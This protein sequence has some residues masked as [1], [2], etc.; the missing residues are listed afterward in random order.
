MRNQEINNSEIKRFTWSGN[1]PMDNEKIVKIVKD[2][3]SG[4]E[5]KRLQRYAMYY[6]SMNPT[7]YYKY[8]DKEYRGKTPNNFVPTAYY[9]TIV[10][11]MAGYMFQ[12]IQ[13]TNKDKSENIDYLK[14]I[15]FLNDIEVK[16]METGLRALAY[17]KAAELVYTTGDVNSIEIKFVSLDPR[18]VIF[19]YNESIEPE[20][21]CGIIVRTSNDEKYDLM[22]D[23]I[24]AD[25]WQYYYMNNNEL[26]VREDERILF[27]SECPVVEYRTEILN[28]NSS[29]N[30][31]IP[32]I[33]ALDFIM[34]GN[35]NEIARLVD[36][37][38]VIGK[39]IK[40]EDLE[41]MEEWKVLEGM[42]TEDRAEYITK[43]MSPVF[44]EYVSKLLINEIH[45][46]SHVIDWYSPDSGLTGEVS[47]KALITRLFDMDM[48]SQR[49]EKVFRRGT[50]KRIRLIS[51]LMVKK[52]IPISDVEI[53][54]NRTL[55]NTA[56]DTAVA[57]KDV[58]FID[59]ETK[60][61][62]CG[63][64][65]EKIMKRKEEQAKEINISDLIPQKKETEENKENI[66]LFN[67]KTD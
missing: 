17:N 50:K 32:Y 65:A 56:I 49:M 20:V 31:I 25:K 24:Y 23:V 9:S 67:G 1:E 22:I 37:M 53:I 51:E 29:F 47:A 27:F 48:Y 42:K 39:I 34:S 16:D 12:N 52:S 3:L 46:H 14:D 55:P 60:L 8:K 18:Q 41:H 26:T 44:R 5:L 54:Y 19:V 35:S 64:D 28:T 13:Y 58:P 4:E 11:T 45:K 30:V 6:E 15:L 10:D 7:M 40:D 57:L 38:L 59:D 61:E 63:L 62:M 2:Y 21:I 66:M 33:D 36:A 43:D